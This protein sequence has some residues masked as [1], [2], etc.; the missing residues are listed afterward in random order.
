MKNGQYL[1]E[2]QST[3]IVHR[4][5]DQG[6]TW[7]GPSIIAHD[8]RYFLCEGSILALPDG[9]LICYLRENSRK[10]Y[11]AFK[12]FSKDEGRTWEGLYPTPMDGCHRPVTGLLPD[13][14][15]LSPIVTSR[16]AVPACEPSTSRLRGAAKPGYWA[17][18]LR[19]YRNGESAARDLKEMG[20]VICPSTTTAARAP[21]AIP[22]GWYSAM[23]AFS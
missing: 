21:T 13:A 12:A 6:K 17:Q 10:G 1:R 8:E 19:L 5:E 20:G 16:A 18:Y 11:S 15:C 7:Q 3:E 4:S 23:A 9:E 22:A 14:G 2:G